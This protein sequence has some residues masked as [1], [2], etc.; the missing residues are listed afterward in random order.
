MKNPTQLVR[1]VKATMAIEGH[2]LNKK[3][4]DLLELCASGKASTKDIIKN[5]I[6]KY[7]Q[8]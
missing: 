3:E 1:E 2:Q 8:K 6:K 5:L 4:I 7:E